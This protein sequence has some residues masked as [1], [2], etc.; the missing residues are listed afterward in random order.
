MFTDTYAES[1]GT[2]TYCGDRTY[3]LIGGTGIVTLTVPA[4]HV[5]NPATITVSTSNPLHT[6]TYNMELKVG[7]V[8]FPEVAEISIFFDV[9][10]TCEVTNLVIDPTDPLV[11]SSTFTYRVGDTELPIN[12]PAFI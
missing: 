12:Y 3:T 10:V 5:S 11:T 9:I 1:L 8:D 7:L 2:S 4:A 6:N